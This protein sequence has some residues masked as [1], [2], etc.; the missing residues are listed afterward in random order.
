MN[1]HIGQIIKK[2][3][4]L[5]DMS[6]KDFAESINCSRRNVY[7]IFGKESIDT[8]MLINISR[9]LGKNLFKHYDHILEEKHETS[10]LEEPK[11]IYSKEEIQKIK[12]LEK[13][14]QHLEEINKLLK[15][16]GKNS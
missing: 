15:E 14:I 7:A 11:P 2:E 16:K 12:Y 6:V 3:V 13:E 8:N 1:I 9:V 5:S 10:N 4:K